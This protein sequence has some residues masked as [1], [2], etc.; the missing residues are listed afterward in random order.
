MTVFRPNKI[1][2]GCSFK[3]VISLTHEVNIQEQTEFFGLDT[4]NE[5][6]L[7]RKNIKQERLCE[8]AVYETERF[9]Q[10][11]PKMLDN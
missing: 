6:T 10:S 3:L 1:F 2:L 7:F 8:G 11:E 9:I 5:R 4:A